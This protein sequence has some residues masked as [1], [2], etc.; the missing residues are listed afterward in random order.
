VSSLDF[1]LEKGAEHAQTSK[2]EA[3]LLEIAIRG[4]SIECNHSSSKVNGVRLL[5]D[6]AWGIASST[7]L[8]CLSLVD[9]ALKQ[10]KL[11]KSLYSGKV[12]IAEAKI[13]KGLFKF[14]EGKPVDEEEVK[15]LLVDLTKSITN[16]L[17]RVFIEAVFTK[18][19]IVRQ[20]S[21]SDG[22]EASEVKSLVDLTLSVAAKGFVASAQTGGVGGLEVL[23]GIE[24]SVSEVVERIKSMRKARFLNPVMR[25]AKMPVVLSKEAACGFVHEVVHGLEADVVVEKGKT[26]VRGSE[27]LTIEDNPFTGYGSYSFDDEGVLA[28]VKKLVEEGRVVDLLHTRHTAKIMG[29]EPKGNG[30]G[31]YTIPK[32]FSSN[33]A[34]HSGSWEFDEMVEEIR[35]GFVVEGLVKA[36]LQDDFIAIYPEIAYYVKKGEIACPALIN[37]I[38]IPSKS[39]LKYVKG[40]G[41]KKYERIAYEKSFATSESTPPVLISAAVS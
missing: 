7:R 13:A 32:A 16:E 34:V 14:K 19:K 28:R 24:N 38:K 40:V 20:I 6:G 2:V 36:E 3:D 23:E 22:G 9:L 41:L 17:G 37:A 12:E 29:E 30:R 31:L 35:E 18:S 1:A 25:G 27:E 10:A 15:M 21:T 11:A 5:Y 8:N 39:A 26:I 4:P 33:I